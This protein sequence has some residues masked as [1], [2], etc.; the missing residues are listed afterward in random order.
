MATREPIYV[1]LSNLVF[2]DPR[3]RAAFVS[4]GRFLIHHEQLPAGAASCPA[5]YLV[6]HPGEEHYRTGKGI[7][8]KR[9]LKCAFVM[10]FWSANRDPLPAT[11]CNNGLDVLDDLLNNPGNPQNTQTL[12]GLVEHVYLEGSTV[13][14]EGLLQEFSIVVANVTIMI[15]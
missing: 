9:T 3:I 6:E 10:Y 11:L 5:I 8:D 2:N 14:A 15:P 13:V 1:A 7:S 12:G 4:T